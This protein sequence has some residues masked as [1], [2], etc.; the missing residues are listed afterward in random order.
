MTMGLS[1]HWEILS[2]LMTLV[3]IGKFISTCRLQCSVVVQ[4]TVI[5][6]HLILYVC[7]MNTIIPFVCAVCIYNTVHAMSYDGRKRPRARR[8]YQS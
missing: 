7:H 1:I 5:E 6:S 4:Y 2:Q 8:L 3:R